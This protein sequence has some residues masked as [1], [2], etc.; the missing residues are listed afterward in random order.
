MSLDGKI[1]NY[2]KEQINITTDG[3]KEMLYE[4]RIIADAVMVGGN[5]LLQDDPKL[6]VK[7]KERQK[8]RVKL[9]KTPEPI[10]VGVISNG[11]NIKI[12]GDFLKADNALKIIFTTE[13]TSKKKIEKLK[14][15]ASVYILGKNTVNLNKAVNILYNLGIRKLMVEGGGTLI[16]SLLEKELVDEIN[17]K[18]GNL[19]VGGK[20]SVTFVGGKGFSKSN[21]KKVKFVKIIKKPNCLILKAKLIY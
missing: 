6:L 9:G 20:D 17:L 5:T 14:Q 18:I 3:D 19:L 8:K 10:K 12:N 1:S 15:K 2:K 16:F 11:D 13:Q 4:N 7:T 21:V